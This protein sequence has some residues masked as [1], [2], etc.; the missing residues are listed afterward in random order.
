MKDATGL[1]E[2]ERV[3]LRTAVEKEEKIS[4]P[5][6]KIIHYA[7]RELLRMGT[8]RDFQHKRK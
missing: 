4:R 7:K 2:S 8:A 1:A 6:G 5:N 3:L